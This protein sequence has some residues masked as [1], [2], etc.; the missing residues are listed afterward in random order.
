M[1][2]T[3]KPI[4]LQD[5]NGHSQP[6][7]PKHAARLLAYPGTQWS[8]KEPKAPKEAGETNESKPKK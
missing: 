4:V 1:A 8:E 5:Q 3:E 6:F 2:T 7:A